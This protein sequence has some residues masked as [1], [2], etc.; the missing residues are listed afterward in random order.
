[1]KFPMLILLEVFIT[2]KY[3]IGVLKNRSLMEESYPGEVAIDWFM[4]AL[5]LLN[6]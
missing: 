6:V 1:M 5:S 4:K 2:C 3:I